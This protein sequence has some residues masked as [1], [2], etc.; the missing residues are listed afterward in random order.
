MRQ[1]N[2]NSHLVTYEVVYKQ[3][4]QV[5]LKHLVTQEEMY[6]DHGLFPHC[7]KNRLL[8]R[9]TCY[10]LAIQYYIQYYSQGLPW[11]ALPS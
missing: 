4:L 2:V 8:K 10:L 5:S 6:I 1:P 7:T 3:A 9:K 11:S